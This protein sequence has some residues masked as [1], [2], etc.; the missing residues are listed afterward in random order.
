MQGCSLRQFWKDNRNSEA[1]VVNSASSVQ[2][3]F[4]EDV[5]DYKIHIN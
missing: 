4:V 2:T 3:Y 5:Q 1:V